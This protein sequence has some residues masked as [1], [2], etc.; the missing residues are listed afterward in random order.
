[1]RAEDPRQWTRVRLAEK[2]GCSPFFVSLC[3]SAPQIAEERKKELEAI[4]KKWGRSKTEAREDR[5][6]R[7][8]MWGRV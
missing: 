3:A 1:M 5:Q 2:F 4:K 6:R 8:E 7:K